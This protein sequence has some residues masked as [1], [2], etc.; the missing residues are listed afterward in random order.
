MNRQQINFFFLT[1]TVLLVACGSPQQDGKGGA[2]QA[3]NHANHGG[4]FSSG[5]TYADSVNEGLIPA[6]TLKISVRR[7]AMGNI[8]ECHVHIE[9]G[10]PGVRGRNIWGGLV[11]FDEVWA[12]GA[13]S[14]TSVRFSKTVEVNGVR[15]D[16]GT[17]GFFA[18]PG[19]KEWILIL[20]S[21]YKQHLTDEY[22]QEEDLVRV[23]VIPEAVDMVPRLTYR[24]EP[25][26]KN[27]TTLEGCIGLLWDTVLV[28]MPFM[29]LP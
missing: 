14:A 10:S 5:P 29:V 11:A 15:I 28:K 17:Y 6:D 21:R 13:H 20:N 2:S 4:M 16:A 26:D 3:D 25:A 12:A 7:V 9:Y 24:V 19:Q 23:K 18:I 8:G 27:E 22:R 1:C